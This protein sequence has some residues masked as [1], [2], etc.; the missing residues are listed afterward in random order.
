MGKGS[1]GHA[2]DIATDIVMATNVSELLHDTCCLL[3]GSSSI[4][5]R[6]GVTGGS[7]EKAQCLSIE[8][9]QMLD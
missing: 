2:V 4:L 3:F 5:L 7:I 6:D 9:A 8:D 1:G